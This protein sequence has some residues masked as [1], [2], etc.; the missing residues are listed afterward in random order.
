MMRSC[1][2]WFRFS[3]TF[4]VLGAPCLAVIGLMTLCSVSMSFTLSRHSSTGLKPVSIL[5]ESFRAKGLLAL[6]M[7]I[8]SFSLVG[9]LMFW[10]SGS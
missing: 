3:D 9:S 10:A 4:R 7:S 1:I 6:A 8:F 2:L 5:I